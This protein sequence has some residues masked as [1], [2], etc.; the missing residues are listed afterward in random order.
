MKKTLMDRLFRWKAAERP[1]GEAAPTIAS[2]WSSAI[3]ACLAVE[4][5]RRATAVRCERLLRSVEKEGDEG[6][7]RLAALLSTLNKTS[8]ISVSERYVAMEEADLFGNRSARL[9]MLD[10]FETP[11]RR[12]IALIAAC[13]G[14]PDILHKIEEAAGPDLG[15]DI[16]DI[17]AGR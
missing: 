16:A 6:L 9:A 4:G 11:R 5:G 15:K 17:L 10:V 14:G 13:P 1:D 7:G 3:A 12:M 2:E 8:A